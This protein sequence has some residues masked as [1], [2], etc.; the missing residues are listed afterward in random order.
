MTSKR[1]SR[2]VELPYVGVV[3]LVHEN[4]IVETVTG[5]D[6]VAVRKVPL[7]TPRTYLEQCHKES[8][9]EVLQ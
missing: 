9:T 6:F 8:V 3:L 5:V 7:P 1:A 2:V 4:G